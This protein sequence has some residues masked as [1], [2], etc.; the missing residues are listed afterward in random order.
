MSA[1]QYTTFTS[2]EDWAKSDEY[3]NGF[4]IPED[5]VIEAAVQNSVANGLP[6]IAVSAAQ[7]KFLH[8]LARSVGAKRILEVGTLGGYS[9]IWL[10]RALPDDGKL[11][12]LE[13]SEKHAKVARENVEKAGLSSKVEVKVGPAADTIKTLGTDDELFDLVFIDADKPGNL[14]YY[15][16]AKRLTRKGAVILVDNIVRSGRVALMPEDTPDETIQ[17]IRKLLKHIQGDKDVDATTIAWVG[18]KGFD[19]L[20]YSVKL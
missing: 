16:E 18:S 15:L 13:L 6:D 19:G 11:I 14:N 4:L 10:A 1:P 7:G 3:H 2:P 9:T 12:T 5:P 8:L 20:L 17:G